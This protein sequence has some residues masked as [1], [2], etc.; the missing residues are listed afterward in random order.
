MSGA[1]RGERVLLTRSEEDSRRL[2][3][4]IGERGGVASI[5]PLTRIA[6]P[7]DP[8][9][10]Q[11][12]RARLG[13]YDWIAVT[14]RHGVAAALRGVSPPEERRPR[15][16]AV[17]RSTARES[18]AAGWPADLVAPR[19]DGVSLAEE[20]ERRFDLD[21]AAV[22]HP[23]SNLSPGGLAERLRRAGATVRELEAYRTLPPEDGGAR[24]RELVGEARPA[25]VVFASPSAVHRFVELLGDGGAIPSGMIA[26]AIGSTTAGAA[27]RAQ[28]R[29][30][31]TAETRD[32]DGLLAALERA[33]SRSR[34]REERGERETR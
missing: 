16:A 6:P 23:T 8:G 20:L 17:G 18:L 10:L 1:L 9:P 29:R 25:A 34:P 28:A 21:G 19:G 33:L 31:E 11:R 15:V 24:L 5:A 32:D 30:I 22:L 27:R 7:A 2:A 12:E 26:V 3:A 13:S 4:A 14:S